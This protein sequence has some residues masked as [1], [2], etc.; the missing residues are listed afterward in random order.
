VWEKGESGRNEEG[1]SEN[2]EEWKF[3]CGTQR[4][5]WWCGTVGGKGESSKG[6]GKQL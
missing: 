3:H 4:Q 1:E 2:E 5:E 6:K